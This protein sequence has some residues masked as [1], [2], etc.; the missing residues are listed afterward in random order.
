MLAYTELHSIYSAD[1]KLA[2]SIRNADFTLTKGS[3]NYS[4]IDEI[5]MAS[6]GY[7][8]LADVT[9]TEA[10]ADLD[11]SSYKKWRATLFNEDEG[12]WYRDKKFIYDPSAS[13]ISDEATPNVT[14]NGKPVF[15]SRGNAWVLCIVGTQFENYGSKRRCIR[16]L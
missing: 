14:P 11:F 5:Y 6:S 12:L 15:W 3:L 8:Y 10:Y 9:G 7:Q 4:W 16:R 13:Y 1:R 2:D